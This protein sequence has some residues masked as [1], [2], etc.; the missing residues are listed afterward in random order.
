MTYAPLFLKKDQERRLLA[1][2][3]WVY[4]NEIDTQRSPLK[5]F[6][7]GEWVEFI[8]HKNQRLGLGYIN[9]NTLLC[10][11]L[12]TRKTHETLDRDF[13]LRRLTN[14]LNL[15][16]SLYHE[17]YYRLAYGESDFLPG[18]IIDRFNQ[19]FVVQITTAGMEAKKNLIAEALIELFPQS[20][21]LLR[22]DNPFRELEGLNQALETIHG[23]LAPA[24][25]VK[26]N[27][28]DFQTNLS[29]GQK[30]GWFYDHRESR[31]LAAKLAAG[32]D[33][34][35]LFSYLGAFAI[36][37][38]KA[39][40]NSVIAVDASRSAVDG[41]QTNAAHNGVSHC[42]TALCDDVFDYLT[43]AQQDI[44]AARFDLIILDP[45][46]LIKRKKDHPQGLKAYEKL[47]QLALGLLKPGGYLFSASCSM[48][49]SRDDLLNCL[50]RAS[51]KAKR[52]IKILGRL[53]Q[54]M[55]HPI[56]PAIPET[57]YLKGFWVSA[58]DY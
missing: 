9:P 58:G 6:Q 39:G 15:R 57:E 53:G 48:H 8:S 21:I 41:I 52:P 29:L 38:A 40:A 28:V 42:V 55:D 22:N 4:S 24:S 56:H 34:L 20:N 47:N 23:E 17:P 35:D 50:R 33:V 25:L 26:E 44:N 51:L 3:L 19:D 11:R 43:N 32:R 5:N 7:P 36:P 37:I 13:F 54:G 1:G 14:T 31:A 49:L 27:G 45:P 10:A 12:V 2:H 30:T 16:D 46:A 18:L